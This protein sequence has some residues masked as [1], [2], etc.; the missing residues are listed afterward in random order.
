MDLASE[1]KLR[2]NKWN[3]RVFKRVYRELGKAYTTYE[4]HETYYDADGKP[5]G[6][7]TDPQAGPDESVEELI[8]GLR[9]MA[10]DAYKTRN[11]VLD[12]ARDGK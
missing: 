7:S 8:E 5:D 2:A 11:D 10:R 6:W 1:R 3:Y 4:L 9:M 12:Y